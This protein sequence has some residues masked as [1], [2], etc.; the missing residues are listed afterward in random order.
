M[1]KGLAYDDIPI[2]S[3]APNEVRNVVSVCRVS[4]WAANPIGLPSG[5]LSLGSNDDF[6]RFRGGM[7]KF[8]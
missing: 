5:F 2:I 1:E 3:T 8:Y 4:F 6:S 7:R